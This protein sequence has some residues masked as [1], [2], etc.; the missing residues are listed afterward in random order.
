MKEEPRILGA[1]TGRQ[2]RP[3]AKL[4]HR[5]A[6]S[7]DLEKASRSLESTT[8]RVEGAGQKLG[9]A[10]RSLESLKGDPSHDALA[11]R[12][13]G[14]VGRLKG[15]KKTAAALLAGLAIAIGADRI[16][17]EQGEPDAAA[18][19][20]AETP[21]RTD[22]SEN[23]QARAAAK[24]EQLLQVLA[25]AAERMQDSAPVAPEDDPFSAE[26]AAKMEEEAMD[27]EMQEQ[28]AREEDEEAMKSFAEVKVE[29]LVYGGTFAEL[30]RFENQE[31]LFEYYAQAAREIGMDPSEFGSAMSQA[32]VKRIRE[33]RSKMETSPGSLTADERRVAEELRRQ[34]RVKAAADAQGQQEG[35]TEGTE[36]DDAEQPI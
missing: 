2:E 26:Y 33:V 9:A 28:I 25:V 35:R 3:A 10:G 8:A 1:E 27:E 11:A 12:G 31:K 4:E 36:D 21:G 23:R 30:I 14:V 32:V 24:R 19:K 34:D 13:R 16:T 20:D 7:G 6:E 5:E 15:L 29:E 18:E 17:P 22:T